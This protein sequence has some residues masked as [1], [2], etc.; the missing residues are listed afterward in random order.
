MAKRAG[1]RLTYANVMATV[2]VFIALGGTS[3]AAATLARD[4]VGSA[5]IRSR[6]VGPTELR[7]RSVTSR[8]VRDRS[9]QPRDL[10]S[11]ARS[12]LRGERGPVGPAGPT[13]PAGAPTVSY[14]AAINSGGGTASG[15][16]TAQGTGPGSA[17]IAFDRDVTGCVA[18]AT[19]AVVPGGQITEPPAGA[20]ANVRIEGGKVRVTT[21]DETNARKNLPFHLIV[22]C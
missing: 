8:A 5:Q 3:Y 17:L 6:A 19:P 20:T 11:E 13:G 22:A 16:G 9:L 21:F 18:T 1:E 12:A 7:S 2:A 14:R 15:N 10:S 4:S